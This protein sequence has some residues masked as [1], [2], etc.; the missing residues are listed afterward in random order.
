[1][2]DYIYIYIVYEYI[3]IILLYSKYIIRDKGRVD[4]SA[5]VG[6]RR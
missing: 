5:I 4:G 1:M 2:D 3:F 6:D